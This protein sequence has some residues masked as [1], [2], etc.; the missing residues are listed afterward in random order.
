M[1]FINYHPPTTNTMLSSRE[2]LTMKYVAESYS[3]QEI[4]EAL[5]LSGA[6]IKQYIKQTTIKLDAKNRVH[7]VSILYK[8][9]LL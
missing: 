5:Y 9:Q 2:R 8:Q 7:A 3:T 4:A 1:R 6:T